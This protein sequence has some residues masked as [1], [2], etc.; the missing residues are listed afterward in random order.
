MSAA[1]TP[2][3]AAAACSRSSTRPAARGRT[4][5]CS[6]RKRTCAVREHESAQPDGVPEP[7]PH[8]ARARAARRRPD[9]RSGERR[10]HADV[11][12][13]RVDPVR[14]VGVSRSR[15][16]REA[17]GSCGACSSS[18]AQTIHPA[19][20]KGAH[21]FGVRAAQGRRSA[22]RHARRDGHAC[23]GEGDRLAHDRRGRLGAAI[24]ARRR[25]SDRG[26]RRQRAA[27]RGVCRC[28]RRC[29]RRRVS[30]CR[31]SRS[32]AARCLGGTSG[33]PASPRSA[34]TSTSSATPA[35]ARRCC[36]GAR[37]ST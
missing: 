24:S 27:A 30:C 10:R 1:A 4:T 16:P 25:R 18:C 6:S 22:R 13:H 17:C 23:D 14:G 15:A 37:S 19:F 26:D 31:G 36:C 20:D 35:R 7:A 9:A 3:G 2:T 32:S 34:P 29:V 5:R 28:T 11:G 21:Y 8:G 12:R 33:S